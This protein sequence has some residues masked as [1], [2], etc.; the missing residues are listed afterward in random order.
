MN[1]ILE[2]KTVNELQEY[3]FYIP[4]YQRGYRWT[5]K[6]VLELLNDISNFTPRLV[7]DNTEERTWYCLQPI[8]IKEREDSKYEVIDGQQRLT[9]I[10]LILHYLNQD[11]V[12][13]R[14]DQL[15]SLDY[16]TR[17]SSKDFLLNLQEDT[18]EKN[19]DF[20]YIS[21]AY[22]TISNWF[23]NKSINFDKG[24]FR[25]KFKFNSK[26]IWYLSKE[27]DSISIFTRINIGKIPLTNSELIKALFLNSSNFNKEDNKLRLRQ[28]E[29]ATEWDNIENS[30]QNNKFW[31]FLN[32][33]QIST[34]RIEFIFNLM[35]DEP[36][37]EDNYSTFR[38]FSKKFSS[39]NNL[40]LDNNWQEVKR[41]FQRFSE[42]FNERELY[43]KIGFLI[44]IDA[45]NIKKLYQES[46]K[47]TKS[48]FKMYLDEL[49][50][51]QFR[52]IDLAELQYSD[53]KEV[54]KVLLLYNILTM[55]STTKD[56]SY[57]PFDLYK[58]EKWD[59]EHITSIK[60]KIPEHNKGQWL[61]DAITF[62]GKESDEEKSLRERINLW[63]DDNDD[64]FRK[65]F[66]DI[67]AYFNS[68]LNVDDDINSLSNLTLLD[69]S[70]NRSYKNAVFPFKR[71]IIIDRD[72]KGIFIPIC[73][74]NVFLKYFSDYPP[75]ISFW[76]QE[77][78]ENY[79]NDL[80]K[81]LN[82][83][84]GNNGN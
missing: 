64:E 22:K 63:D 68:S 76:S 38:F 49:I 57:F 71:R 39:G 79:E 3:N 46:D 56:N 35:N 61:S 50:K 80:F 15:F 24:N 9:T 51:Y 28:L 13:N 8:V 60:D 67:V 58:N 81:V 53:T 27:S 18:N 10:Y 75:K 6:E 44:S 59:I 74:K 45:V 14:R 69:S 5:T 83:Y 70:T 77:D 26:V 52:S 19:I 41:Y 72:R 66:E 11:F 1:N 73:T 23:N 47:A 84:L 17:D 62:I 78:R 16:Q 2:L 25:S 65:L 82:S 21:N 40:T 31:Y 55:L 42:W 30:L 7:N 48:E 36:D 29:I 4:S 33:N 34:N 54:R 20:Y 12:E 32:Q 37:D 43:H